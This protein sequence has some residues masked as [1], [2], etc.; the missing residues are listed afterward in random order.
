[1][2]RADEILTFWFG[3]PRDDEKYYDTWHKRWFTPDPLFDLAIR[4]RFLEDYHQA[5]AHALMDWQHIARSGLALILLCD[6]FPRNMFRNDP[7]AFATDP[8]ARTVATHLIE[9]GLDRQLLPVERSFIYMPFMHSEALPDQQRSVLLFRQLTEER[10]FLNSVPY[11][12][13]HQE[14]IERFGRFPHRNAILSRLS[15]PEEVEFLKQPG[16][17]F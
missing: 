11:A 7:R 14:I 16:S 17:S 12:L 2:S 3:T 8:L 1:M 13:K 10:E 9:V 5:T 6:Q 15:T 4:E